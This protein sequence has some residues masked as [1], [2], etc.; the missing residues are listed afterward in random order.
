M[1]IIKTTDSINVV[2]VVLQGPKGSKGDSAGLVSQSF[3][4]IKISGSEYSG[5]GDGSQ[6]LT[7]LEVT[8]SILPEGNGVW[9]LGSATNPF[10][11]LYVA[12]ESINLVDT[13]TGIATKLTKADVDNLKS[14]KPIQASVE[15]GGTTNY[16][17]PSAILHPTNET[18]ILDLGTAGR[19]AYTG[20]GGRI[21]DIYNDGEGDLASNNYITLGNPNQTTKTTIVGEGVISGSLTITGSSTLTN[22]GNFKNRMHKDSHYFTVTTN[23]FAKGGWKSNLGHTPSGPSGSTPHLH[24]QLSGSGVAGIGTLDPQHTLHVSSSSTD[25]NA[26]Q[27][28]GQSQFNGMVAGMTLGNATTISSHVNVPSGYNALLYTSNANPSITV[29]AGINYTINAGADVLITNMNN[30]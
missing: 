23:P 25:F 27:V 8:G 6:K 2:E 28:E 5:S 15:K 4:T 22:W 9:D 26:F 16:I 14:G 7:A 13:A 20:L 24:F 3:S 1:A 30:I 17:R 10:K 29:N 21:L 18:P 11:E 19:I 12:S